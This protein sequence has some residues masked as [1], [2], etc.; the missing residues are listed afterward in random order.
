MK[1]TALENVYV[2]D[3]ETT[4][5]DVFTHLCTYIHVSPL[6]KGE[7]IDVYIDV[8]GGFEVGQCSQ[9]LLRVYKSKWESISF[10]GGGIEEKTLHVY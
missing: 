10:Q 4:G 9:R 7:G 8:P 3:L 6:I 5:P 2:V 1:T